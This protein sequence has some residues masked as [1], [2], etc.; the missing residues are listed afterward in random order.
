MQVQFLPH[1]FLS[2]EN[3]TSQICDQNSTVTVVIVCL[4]DNISGGPQQPADLM[5][6][7]LY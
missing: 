1:I 5:D 3:N 7:Y 4:D 2:T 6:Q